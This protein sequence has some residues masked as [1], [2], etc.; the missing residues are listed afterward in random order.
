MFVFFERNFYTI[1]FSSFIIFFLS[2]FRAVKKKESRRSPSPSSQIVLERDEEREERNAFQSKRAPHLFRSRGVAIRIGSTSWPRRRR[3]KRRIE[4]PLCL[5]RE[6]AK[7]TVPT[8]ETV[9]PRGD[10]P[11]GSAKVYARR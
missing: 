11:L 10:R 2:F 1:F 4:R 8:R 9:G 7:R 6:E 3:K 5:Q